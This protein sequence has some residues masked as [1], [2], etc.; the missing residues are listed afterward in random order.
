MKRLGP[1]Q[2][3][4]LAAGIEAEEEISE[5]LRHFTNPVSNKVE[6]LARAALGAM[7]TMET[8]TDAIDQTALGHAIAAAA[9]LE[10]EA[11]R[12]ALRAWL[13]PFVDLD[14]EEFSE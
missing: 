9:R 12:T 4:Q 5:A 2:F 7:T 10:L 8:Y 11:Q 3:L 6:G 1:I 13:A 14:A